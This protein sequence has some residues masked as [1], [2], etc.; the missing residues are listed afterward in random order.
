MKVRFR[1]KVAWGFSFSPLR[2][3]CSPL[4]GSLAALSYGEKIK[5]NL[6]DQGTLTLF[7][8]N[9]ATQ[10]IMS[11]TSFPGSLGKLLS[12]LSGV[13]ILATAN[14]LALEKRSTDCGK[15][16][17]FGTV[18]TLRTLR[19]KVPRLPEMGKCRLCQR[20]AQKITIGPKQP[21]SRGL[22]SYWFTADVNH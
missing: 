2:D 3:S 6:W 9:M 19:S 10:F 11:H 17:K 16:E 13:A 14:H 7:I 18:E 1:S 15:L 4:H 12:E 5:E 21:P 8:I 22:S 20:P